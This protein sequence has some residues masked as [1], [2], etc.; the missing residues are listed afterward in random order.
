MSR[1]EEVLNVG[2]MKRRARRRLPGA[3]FDVIEGGAGDETTVL[4]NRRGWS[5][6]WLRPHSLIDVTERDLGTEILGA[7][8]S[9][10]V[11][12]APCGFARMC[13]PD[14][15]LAIARAAGEAGALYAVSGA[16]AYSLEEIKAASTGPTW[17]QF[18]PPERR[19]DTE[20]ELVRIRE[21]GYRVLCVTVDEA[22]NGIRD[23]D[24]YNR[25]T[26]PLRYSPR[27]V[28]QG[29]S[30]PR[31][32]LRF[33]FGRLGQGGAGTTIQ[34]R[35]FARKVARC[36]PIT[37]EEIVWMKERFE[38]PVV[39]KGVQR[40]EGVAEMID[41]GV[42]GIVVSN[43]GGRNLDGA[44]PT[45]DILPEVVAAA[46]GRAEVFVDGGIER[47]VDVLRALALGA[48]GVLVGRAYMWGLSAYGQAGVRR[49]L[50]ILRTELES[51]MGLCG[52]PTV[53]S[54]DPSIVVREPAPAGM[55][56][57][58][59]RQAPDDRTAHPDQPAE[60]R[61]V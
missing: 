39:V 42:D 44:R 57:R 31:W 35:E 28:R 48:R 41:A 38:G 58:C 24:Y 17:Y 16:A 50:E 60:Q 47:G 54:I 34:M 49:V 33:S 27:I 32:A 45:A 23:R 29:I 8:V 30:R 4:G 46:G 61:G 20:T 37:L 11:I 19:E 3:I 52:C 55:G 10:P 21:A 25:I 1:A 40:G 6:H 2:E 51:A 13:D 56:G 5:H 22:I 26:I 14:G 15:E 9:M 43:H 12:V 18:F 7:P 59:S 53:A 36:R